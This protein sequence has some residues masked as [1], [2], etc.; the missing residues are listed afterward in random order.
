MKIDGGSELYQSQAQTILEIFN[1]LCQPERNLESSCIIKITPDLKKDIYLFSSEK[2]KIRYDACG[3]PDLNGL[4]AQPLSDDLVFTILIS[5]KQFAD[6]QYIHTLIHELVHFH[7]Y[8]RYYKE[9]GNLYIKNVQEQDKHY[10]REFYCWSEFH[11]KSVGTHIFA[12]YTYHVE[13]ELEVP[14]DGKY[15]MQIDPQTKTVEDSL[16]CFLSNKLPEKRN[17]LFWK[18]VYSLVGYYGRLSIDDVK[19][20][21]VIRDPSFPREKLLKAFGKPVIELFPLLKG[22]NTYEKAL[23]GLPS[24]K[25]LFDQITRKLNND[26]VRWF[27]GGNVR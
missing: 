23:S 17:D 9:N 5:E 27:F 15:S 1:A 12:I 10:F 11:A 16:D 26:V 7:D 2:D 19:N 13:Y 3:V 4:L 22:M 14:P 8:Y 20:P 21:A 18:F 25:S 6:S 24:L